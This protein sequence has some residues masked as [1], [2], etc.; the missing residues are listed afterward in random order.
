M[1][2]LI[3]GLIYLIGI[4]FLVGFLV[5]TAIVLFKMIKEELL[6]KDL[7]GNPLQKKDKN[8]ESGIM[9]TIKKLE[10]EIKKF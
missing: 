10:R 3:S 2:I 7:N 1:E 8:P 5:I 4:L 9:N 6:Q